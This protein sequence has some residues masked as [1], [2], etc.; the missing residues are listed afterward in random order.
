MC[1]CV[2]V[3]GYFMFGM[4]SFPPVCMLS[5][6]CLS[7]HLSFHHSTWLHLI[8]TEPNRTDPIQSNPILPS[9]AQLSWL[10]TVMQ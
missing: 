5:F 1:V 10:L 7:S 8:Q 9:S 4:L 2:C 3:Y 6:A